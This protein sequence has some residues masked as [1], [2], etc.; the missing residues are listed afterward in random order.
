MKATRKKATKEAT[1]Q[2]TKY[3]KLHLADKARFEK[4]FAEYT[5]QQE[6]SQSSA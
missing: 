2:Y 5:K 6:E 1:K 3:E 4:E